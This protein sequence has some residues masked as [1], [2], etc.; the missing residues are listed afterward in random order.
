MSSSIIAQL[1]GVIAVCF[2]LAIFQVNKRE[3]MLR[4]GAVAGL[5][6]AVHFFLIGAPTGAAMNIVGSIRSYIFS[7]IK[8][9]RKN[10]W[11]L[12]FFICVSLLGAAL[13]W[14]GALSLLPMGGIIF[15]ALAFWQ[16]NPTT[17]RR[18]ALIAS[19]LWF[20]YNAASGSYPGMFIEIFIMTSN[21]IGQ[22]RFDFRGKTSKAIINK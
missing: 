8:P 13:T 7:I 9:T 14:E 10:I 18:L 16:S 2:S 6:Y 3:I 4:I 17:I 15:G 21:L 22:Y 5:L 20:I 12:V 19:P 1:I 11:I